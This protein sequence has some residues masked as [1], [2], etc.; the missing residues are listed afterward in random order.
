MIH[1]IRWQVLFLV[2]KNCYIMNFIYSAVIFLS[3][4][5]VDGLLLCF[6]QSWVSEF[7]AALQQ[8]DRNQH[9]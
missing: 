8:R 6:S 5:T 7:V 2:L 4:N 1:Q 9:I 3:G